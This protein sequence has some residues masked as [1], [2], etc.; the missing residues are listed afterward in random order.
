LIVQATAGIRR[1]GTGARK[2]RAVGSA[3]SDFDQWIQQSNSRLRVLSAA[4][5]L[6]LSVLARFGILG[7]L[8]I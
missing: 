6:Q 1:R 5:K 4:E 3:I 8:P 7:K 2:G